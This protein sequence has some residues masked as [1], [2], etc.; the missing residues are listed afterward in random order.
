[1]NNEIT[2]PA[3]ILDPERVAA[4]FAANGVVVLPEFCTVSEMAAVSA[5]LK[6]WLQSPGAQESVSAPGFDRH[7]TRGIGW[8]PI[9]DGCSSFEQL[10][11]HPRMTAVTSAILGSDAVADG[12]MIRLSR[13][14]HQQAWHQ[15]SNSE[16]PGQFLVNRLLYVW[17]VDP[18][19]GALVCVPGSHRAG[20]IPTGDPHGPLAG[21][22]AV[23]PRAGTLVLVHSRCYH[24]VTCNTTTDQIRISVNFRVSPAGARSDANRYGVY[25]TGTYDH[26]AKTNMEA[27]ES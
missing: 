6:A 4:T 1:M 16:E 10:R 22:V 11:V 13:N 19:A 15:D 23:A 3:G 2:L 18:R 8:L 21:E 25:R 14:G 27:Q 17:D 20:Q 7:Q 5:D 24:R 9:V 12:C 26:Y